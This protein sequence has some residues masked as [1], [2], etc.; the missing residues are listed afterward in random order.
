MLT[1]KEILPRQTKQTKL[2]FK[3]FILLL[4]VLSKNLLPSYFKFYKNQG[5][6]LMCDWFLIILICGHGLIFVNSDRYKATD[7]LSTWGVHTSNP[8]SKSIQSVYCFEV[9]SS[10]KKH[11][12]TKRTFFYRTIFLAFRFWSLKIIL[13]FFT[14]KNTDV[15]T[16][17]WYT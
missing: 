12:F 1:R 4:F 3:C 2:N 11:H 6:W 13:F 17:K 10:N 8:C 5:C 16:Q 9:W 15:S 14:L 7:R